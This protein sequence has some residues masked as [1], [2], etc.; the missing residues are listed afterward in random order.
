MK[1]IERTAA[2]AKSIEALQA[3]FPWFYRPRAN[4]MSLMYGNRLIRLAAIGMAWQATGL[5]TVSLG[6]ALIGTVAN[7][8]VLEPPGREL[9]AKEP[10]TPLEL[11]DAIDYLLRPTRRR[12]QCRT[13]NGS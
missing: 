3:G 10:R 2:P 4:W 11:W 9:F 7:S 8:M 13:S 5:M 1:S 6:F 12:R